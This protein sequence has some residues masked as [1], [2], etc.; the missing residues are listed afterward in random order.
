MRLPQ[1][2]AQIWLDPS[3]GFWSCWAT[4]IKHCFQ[5]IYSFIPFLAS[6][7]CFWRW[8]SK[9]ICLCKTLM[10]FEQIQWTKVFCRMYKIDPWLRLWF[11]Q[12]ICQILMRYDPTNLKLGACLKTQSSR[13]IAVLIMKTGLKFLFKSWNFQIFIWI[14]SVHCT[15]LRI[16]ARNSTCKNAKSSCS[17]YSG[18]VF[19]IR[20]VKLFLN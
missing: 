1:V 13:L 10:I 16:I 19:L 3:R 4:V 9:K 15:G 17:F 5:L 20:R 18:A 14:N 11:C 7:G 8:K 12:D 6:Q 2:I